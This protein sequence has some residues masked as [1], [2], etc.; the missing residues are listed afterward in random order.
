[1]NLRRL[2]PFAGL[3]NPKAVWSWGMYDLANQSFTLLVIT[4]LFPIY[5]KKVVVAQGSGDPQL[6]AS[7]DAIWA[8]AQGLSLFV[9]VLISPV[10]GA[11]SDAR[12]LRKEVLIGSGLV[13]SV[14]TCVLALAGAGDVWLTV[15]AFA[16]AN[17]GF[18]LGENFLASFL[19]DLSTRKTIGRISALGW[20]M[21]YSGAVTLLIITASVFAILGWKSEAQWRPMFVF[22]GLW[23]L[24]GMIPA[25]LLLRDDRKPDKPPAGTIWSQ[26][27]G[28]FI[29]TLSHAAH[30]R[31]LVL[32]LGGFLIYA[33]GVQTVIAFAS[34]LAEEFGFKQSLLVLFVLQISVTGAIAAISTA[35]FTDRLGAKRTVIAFLLIWIASCAALATLSMLRARGAWS[36]EW[37][38]WVIGNGLGFGL[39]GIGTATRA[40]VGEFTPRHRSAEFFGLWGLTFKLAGAIGVLSFGEMKAGLGTTAALWML[41]AFFV[42][43]LIVVLFVNER[44]GRL[45]AR[46]AERDHANRN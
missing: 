30:Y 1:M 3:S 26:S 19:P 21:G 46:T 36:P 22:A 45:A 31:Q 24:V 15:L 38:F 11:L 39:G 23:F 28:R 34:I 5:L 18:Q 13:C 17:I 32:F 40:M 35:A 4:L 16:G 7:G 6:L 2:N 43:G 37:M 33:F 10:I 14:L 12:G 8:R 42:A 41:T 27:F 44:A 20:A 25:L 9:V 29:G